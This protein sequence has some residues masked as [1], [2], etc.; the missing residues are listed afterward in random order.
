VTVCWAES[1]EE[2][3]QTAWKQWPNAAIEGAASQELPL[4]EHFEQLAGVASPDDLEEALV[5]GPDADEHRGRIQEYVDA[6]FTHVYVHQIGPDQSGF[7][8][9]ARR[10]LL[11]HFS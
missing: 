10:E 1:A 4:P 2:A 3:K 5:L 11:P 8:D 6:G 9:F 7:L